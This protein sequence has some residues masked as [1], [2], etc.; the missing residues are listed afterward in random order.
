[1]LTRRLAREL[2][3][4]GAILGPLVL[5]PLW[6]RR[7]AALNDVAF[8][9]MA[10]APADRV[11]EIGFGGGYLLGRIRAEVGCGL[12]A[13][14]DVSRAMVAYVE[15]RERRRRTQSR[16]VLRCASAEDLPF[17]DHTF[18]G[19]CSVNSIL[20][21]QDP[22]R[23]LEEAMRVS[24]RAARLVLCFTDK[25]S[26]ARRGFSRHGIRLYEAEEI[27]GMT[28]GAGFQIERLEKL[29]DR[30]RSFWCLTASN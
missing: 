18:T 30:H 2:A 4:P 21:W 16:L 19:L 11:L 26:L 28:E 24:A 25:G 1:M 15:R 17:P 23:A 20:Y 22:S 12:I 3:R 10:L 8:Q 27:R 5:A 9:A 29:S 14:V 7:N 13:G 6:N